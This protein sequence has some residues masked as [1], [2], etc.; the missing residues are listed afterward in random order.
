M[1][2]RTRM[3]QERQTR[4]T[5][6]FTVGDQVRLAKKKPALEK[7]YKT[8]FADEIFKLVKVIPKGK[9]HLYEISDLANKLIKSSFTNRNC[10]NLLCL[11]NHTT[12]V[13]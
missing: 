5:P 2:I 7:G 11:M 9:F 8:H 13:Y 1:G 4:G 6:G 3:L 12:P 10:Q